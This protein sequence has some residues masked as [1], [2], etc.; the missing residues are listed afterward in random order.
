MPLPDVASFISQLRVL[1]FCLCLLALGGV[2]SG[3]SKF[4]WKRISTSFS[5]ASDKLPL[6]VAFSFE[7]HVLSQVLRSG[8]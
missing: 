8:R 3:A 2:G 1:P 5:V 4:K 6:F 7:S